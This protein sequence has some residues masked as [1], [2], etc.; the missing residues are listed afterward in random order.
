VRHFRIVVQN[1]LGLHARPATSFAEVTTAHRCAVR[2]RRA[3]NGEWIDGKS[4]MQMLMLAATAGTTLEVE[5]DGADETAAEQAI[6][7]LVDRRF[8]E[9]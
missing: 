1:R 6:K 8:D 4:I 3:G 7:A 5:C 9:E 2:V